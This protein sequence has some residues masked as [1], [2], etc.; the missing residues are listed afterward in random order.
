[1]AGRFPG[2]SNP[3]ELWQN[4]TEGREA[5]SF[6]S[7]EELIAAGVRPDLI[8]NPDYVTASSTIRDPDYFDAGFFGFSA[9]EAEIIDPQQ[10][11]FLE[12]AWEA[13]ED[14]GCNVAEYEGASAYS[15]AW[16]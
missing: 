14:A 10:R 11:V 9:R 6:A 13:I 4:L 3:R 5:V 7:R 15:P 8:D 2:A 1:M 16:A 12:C